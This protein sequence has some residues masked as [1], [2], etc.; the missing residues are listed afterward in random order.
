V[1]AAVTGGVAL[2]VFVVVLVIVLSGGKGELPELR[3]SK[4]DLVKAQVKTIS[5]ACLMFETNNGRRPE[6]LQELI[7]PQPNAR[8][9]LLPADAI[10][11]PWGKE[12]QYNSTGPEN[13]GAKP[14]VWTETPEGKRIG[15][16]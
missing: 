5:E 3:D 10:F 4:E 12:Y 13:G 11:D 1:L 15:N 8:G 16:W 7:L 2:V 9:S 6:S 14:D